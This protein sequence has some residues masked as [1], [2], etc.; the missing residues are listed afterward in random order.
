MVCCRVNF[1][2]AFTYCVHLHVGEEW[3]SKFLERFVKLLAEY[4]VL[5]PYRS[6]QWGLS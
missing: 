2:F 6:A 1:K 5:R 4:T 3:F